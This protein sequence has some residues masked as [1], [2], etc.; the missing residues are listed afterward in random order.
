MMPKTPCL[1]VINE[2]EQALYCQNDANEMMHLI[3][4]FQLICGFAVVVVCATQ[5]R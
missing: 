5:K 2:R 3:R 4:I 1:A